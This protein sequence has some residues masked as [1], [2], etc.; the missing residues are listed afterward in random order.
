MVCRS[1]YRLDL[2]AIFN[3]PGRLPRH[4]GHLQDGK[5]GKCIN[6]SSLTGNSDSLVGD[7]VNSTPRLAHFAICCRVWLMHTL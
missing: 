3:F 7:G 2:V 1:K 4:G 6:K 5:S